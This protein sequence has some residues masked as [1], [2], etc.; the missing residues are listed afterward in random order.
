VQA[1]AAYLGL[2]FEAREV[3]LVI[4][5]VFFSLAEYKQP[6]DY[7]GQQVLVVKRYVGTPVLK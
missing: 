2:T 3:E 7:L 6:F 4:L 5:D 1:F